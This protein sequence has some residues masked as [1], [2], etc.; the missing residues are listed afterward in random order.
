MV[1]RP[2][3]AGQEGPE[4]VEAVESLAVQTLELGTAVVRVFFL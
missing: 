3:L 2:L 4:A 1:V